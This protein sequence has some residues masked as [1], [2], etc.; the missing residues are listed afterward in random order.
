M[1]VVEHLKDLEAK[2]LELWLQGDQLRYRAPRDLLTPQVLTELKQHK[3]EIC[4]L[5]HKGSHEAV[6]YPLS[7][8]QQALWFLHQL[9]PES[10]AYNGGFA[11]RIRSRV[12]IPA[13]RRALQELIARHAAL[14]TTFPKHNGEPVQEIHQHQPLYFEQVDASQW[15]WDV[16]TVRVSAAYKRPFQL[17][18]G[19]VMRVELFTR[20]ADDY[21]LLL[22]IHHIACDGWSLWLLLDELRVLYP[23]QQQGTVATLPASDLSY[24]DYVRWQHQMLASPRG[25]WL[26]AYW[27]RQL[28]GELPVLNLPTDRPRPAVQTYNGASH[29]FKLPAVL[30]ERLRRLSQAEQATLYTTL[31]AAFQVLLY[32]YTGQEDILLGAPTAGRSHADFAEIVGDMT[33]PVALRGS[34][35]DNPSFTAFLAQVRQTVLDAMTHEDFP[36]ALLVER[37][38]LA[39]DP[40]RS[41]LF[42]VMFNFQQ[43]QRFREVVALWVADETEAQVEWGGMLLEPFAL[44][45]QEGQMDLTL[46]MIEG[47]AALFGVFKYNPDLFDAATI[48]R[49]AG[50]FQTLIEGI[51]AHPEQRIAALPLLTEPEQHQL[52]VTWNNTHTDYPRDRCIHQLF[53]DQVQRTPDAVAVVFAEQQLTYRH[54]QTRADALARRLRQAGVG[55]NALV[56]LCVERSPEMLVGLLGILKAGAAYLPLDPGHPQKRLAFILQD[57]GATVLVTQSEV[58]AKLPL[59]T[60]DQPASD[61]PPHE[62]SMGDSPLRIVHLA[63][64]KVAQANEG[65]PGQPDAVQPDDLAYVIYTSGSTGTPK[66]VGIPHRA[67]VNLLASMARE[68]GMTAQDT[69]LAVTTLSFDIAGLELLLPLTTGGRVVI[70]PHEVAIDGWQLARLLRDSGATIM[71]ATPATWRLLIESGWQGAPHLKILC[72]GEALPPALARELL[73]RC[74]CLWNMYGPTETTI[75][76]TIT[77]VRSADQITLGR[78]IAN[79]EVYVLSTDLQAVPIG[80]AGELYIGGDGLAKGYWHRPDLTTQRFVPHPFRKQPGARLYKTGDIVAYAQDGQ[81]RYL[82]RADQQV[83]IRGYRVELGEVETVISR[84]P[85]VREAVVMAREVIPGDKQLVGYLVVDT[86]SSCSTTALRNALQEELPDYMVPSHFVVLD[87]LPLNP[88]GKIDRSA[89]PAPEQSRLVLEE[90]WV[91]EPLQTAVEKALADI[92]TEVLGVSQVGR[93]DNFFDLGG[94]SIAAVQTTFKMRQTFNV[95]VSLQTFLK[96]PVL[97][98]Q[99]QQLEEILLSQAEAGELEQLI[100]DIDPLV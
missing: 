1:S 92:W 67:V 15:D 94:H 13:L 72:G 83:K 58:L 93:N 70:A 28:A 56:G 54:L 46:E 50:H 9:A 64:Q 69:L 34:C 57:A 88:S 74:S 7:H 21:I 79:T 98:A 12:D 22:T 26:W 53:Q 78:P 65:V 35:A 48:E 41:P 100:N 33:N 27:Q 82:G 36:F 38:Q 60:P 61:A 62:K 66:G 24:K 16:L 77:Q 73:P 20:A 75:W 25:E 89:L 76:S 68:P 86:A 49:M 85:A 43:P 45:Q 5:L 4:A 71:Q 91:L 97:S 2:G 29:P 8:S 96:T 99:A 84:H 39:R 23:A 52:L 95:D 37:L 59:H 63:P 10:A 18:V 17:E 47:Q 90:A 44:A 55:S 42:Q 11:V 30:T 32:R 19:P 81:L 51:V 87:K 6:L 40:S 80:V 14:R 31:V 3:E